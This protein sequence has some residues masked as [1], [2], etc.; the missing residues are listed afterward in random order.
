MYREIRASTLSCH[1]STAPTTQPMR[2]QRNAGSFDKTATFHSFSRRQISS[3]NS[4]ISRTASKP[5]NHQNEKEKYN[6]LCIGQ[7][8]QDSPKIFCVTCKRR[9]FFFVRQVGGVRL[10]FFLDRVRNSD[11]FSY[12]QRIFWF[13]RHKNTFVTASLA[14]RLTVSNVCG[15]VDGIGWLSP[16]GVR[17]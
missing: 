6:F 4:H 16:D 1:C 9:F 12:F 17:C 11:I 5:K 2:H 13:W 14:V 8:L 10:G 15:W 3:T 7:F